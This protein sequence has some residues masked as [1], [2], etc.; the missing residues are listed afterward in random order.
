MSDLVF[1]RDRICRDCNGTGGT[2]QW[3][4]E[5]VGVQEGGPGGK[6]KPIRKRVPCTEH[7]CPYCNG[8]GVISQPVS[9]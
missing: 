2:H 8:R 3:H 5:T 9:A 7:P 6:D 1:G 4:L